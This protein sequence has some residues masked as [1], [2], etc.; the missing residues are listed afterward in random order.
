MYCSTL[1]ISTH[2]R[3][4]IN[5]NF[6]VFTSWN[7]IVL[8]IQCFLSVYFVIWKKDFLKFSTFLKKYNKCQSGQGRR[9]LFQFEMKFRIISLSKKCIIV[10]FGHFNICPLT[11]LILRYLFQGIKYFWRFN[12]FVPYILWFGRNTLWDLQKNWE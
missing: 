8:K 6:E 2:V 12:I 4:I 5:I 3:W 9:V 7:K 11:N 1:A 10:P